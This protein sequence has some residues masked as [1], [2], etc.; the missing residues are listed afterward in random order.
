[1]IHMADPL[2]VEVIDKDG[3][4]V[5]SVEGT[6]RHALMNPINALLF[7]CALLCAAGILLWAIWV[8]L[9]GRARTKP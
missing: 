8:T 7:L 6:R 4:V 9:Q 5:V 1:M 2:P 3:R